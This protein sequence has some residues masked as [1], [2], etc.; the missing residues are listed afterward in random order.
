M[1]LN[2][3]GRMTRPM[4]E[5]STVAVFACLVALL[6]LRSAYFTANRPTYMDELLMYN[7][8]YM[9][10]HYGKIALPVHGYE[11]LPVIV[12]P[13]IHVGLIGLLCRLGFTW[14]YAEGTPTAFFL[15][16][17]IWIVVRG[18]FPAAVK[19]GLL[20]GIGITMSAGYLP[21]SWF[22][23]RPEGELHAA[24]FAA[25][26][27]LESGRLSGWH[28]GRLFGGAFLLTWASSV[29]YYGTPA[30]FGLAVYLVWAV[31]SL[32][33]K[34]ARPRV[35][36]LV[37]G[38]ALFGLPYLA[39]YIAPNWHSIAAAVRLQTVDGPPIR[40]HLDLY[41][42]WAGYSG[43]PAVLRMALRPGIPLMVFSSA[44]L[45][46]VRSTRGMALASLPLQLG[47]FFFAAHKQPGYLTHELALFAAALAVGVLVS[48]SWLVQRPQFP[49]WSRAIAMPV[50]A[51][52]LSVYL[53]TGLASQAAASFTHPQVHPGDLARA[54]TR[55]ILGPHAR[56]VGRMGSWYS[57][58]A[59]SWHDH[60]HDLIGPQSSSYDP[61]RYLENFDAAADYP[62]LS[63]DD[64]LNPEHKTLSYWYSTGLLKLRGFYFS[65]ETGDL[66]LVLLSVNGPPKVVGYAGRRGVL[67]RFDESVSGDYEVTTATCP[68]LPEF[69][70]S[71]FDDSYPWAS[72]AVLKLPESSPGPPAVIVTVL[73]PRAAAE[74]AGRLRRSCVETGSV[75]GT[76]SK[77]DP[78]ALIASLRRE[79]TPIRFYA[80][81]ED[82]PG[83]TGTGIPRDAVPPAGTAPLEGVVNLSELAPDHKATRLERTPE[84]RVTTP[85]ALGAFAAYFPLHAAGKIAFPLWVR[86]RLRVLSG[87]VGLAAATGTGEIVAL[88]SAL[89]PTPEPVDVALK[90][91]DPRLADDMVVFNARA[92]GA[93]VE[94][95]D[96]MAVASPRDELAYRRLIEASGASMALGVPAE[97]QPPDGA[98]RL[99][100]I[101]NL[102]EAQPGYKT[103]RIEWMPR[104][105][106][107]TPGSGGAFGA[108]FPLHLAGGIA[109]AAWVQV[110][111]HVLSGRIGLAVTGGK[112]GIVARNSR[113]LLPTPEPVDAA[114][115]V[116]DL[117]RGDSFVVFNGSVASASQAEILD[118]AVMVPGN[119]PRHR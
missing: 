104:L 40:R 82:M 6:V 15:L 90:L 52:L 101:L 100:S 83:F 22:G 95:L 67:Y 51:A 88:G 42:Q 30:V 23:T 79:D 109:T 112:S 70:G 110:R 92:G 48:M 78:P 69:A 85:E 75:R 31:R 118:I 76:L 25:L 44:I 34:D 113:W 55:Q 49:A 66:R 96:A 35:L 116:P 50:A 17:G 80:N 87:R 77:A 84:I 18:S 56:V 91:P 117:S 61:V 24:W 86:L 10:A 38:A 57:A 64:S 114:L 14:Y 106:V 63:G 5:R 28:R 20:F 7:P 46:A 45:A 21:V 74:P 103:A 4:V 102:A 32:G 41:R 19:L 119:E 9:V 16:L 111:L 29:H 58:G 89:L 65:Q 39:F 73:A 27:L 36:A 68:A 72:S 60:S 2:W 62:H 43:F 81:I 12:H 97:L 71:G 107:T 108:A 1:K 53:V 47:I 93:Q 33:W 94:I 99:D 59:E 37:G 105:R 98:R 26:V 11:N 13:P 115:P 8:A 54:A 3:P